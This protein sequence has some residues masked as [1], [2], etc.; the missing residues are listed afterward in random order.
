MSKSSKLM[1]ILFAT[2]MILGAVLLTYNLAGHCFWT[3]ESFSLRMASKPFKELIVSVYQQDPHPPLYY[4]FLKFW[5][6]IF[7]YTII[8]GLYFSIIFG[9]AAALLSCYLYSLLFDTRKDLWIPLAI[10][11]TS[12]FFVMFTRMIRYYSYAAFLVVLLLT[13]L[14]KF[15]TS[16][17]R[18]WWW[19]LLGCHLLLI[20]SDYPASTIFLGEF[21]GLLLLRKRFPGKFKQLFLLLLITFVC[22]LPWLKQ[23]LY[24]VTHLS[25]I[26]VHAALSSDYIG[27]VVRTFF[28]IYDFFIGQCI[29]P[30]HIYIT[31]P[32]FLL[33]LTALIVIA[34]HLR[35]LPPIS[36][37]KVFLVI[38]AVLTSF[39]SVILLS[40]KI[41]GKQSFI[42][43]SVRMMFLFIPTMLML[44]RGY[45]LFGRNKY[46]ALIVVL[47]LNMFVLNSYYNKK[48]F[49][50]PLYSIDWQKIVADINERIKP[51][52]IIISDEA[53]VVRYYAQ[54]E[55][56]DGQFFYDD[57]DLKTFI[58]SNQP[59]KETQNI[60][61]IA[62]ERD[63]TTAPEF[64]DFLL[65][66]L[67]KN[68]VVSLRKDY[69]PVSKTYYNI[70]K[71]LTGHAYGH[72]VHMFFIKISLHDLEDYFSQE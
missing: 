69:T 39:C 17:R 10:I 67:M 62:T 22:F 72:K 42:Y 31:L 28:S 50:N 30:W 13:L 21:F 49:L 9:F 55:L 43:I 58:C 14:I 8:P 19:Y 23:L 34:T 53:E 63:S 11:V 18:Q 27:I 32:L 40:S 44:A 1:I 51:G 24:H 20:Y 56:P 2:I 33:H 36:R 70:K 41:V 54:H 68:G 45:T 37:A 3:D 25:S 35:K 48:Y 47:I 65:N 71:K 26:S 60:F 12:P 5:G 61:L 66:F 52:D 6:V 46:I 29:Y 57:S 59:K 15:V 4:I 64:E 7:S 16:S 38:I